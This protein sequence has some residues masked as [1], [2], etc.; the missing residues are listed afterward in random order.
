MFILLVVLL[1]GCNKQCLN[2]CD[3]CKHYSGVINPCDQCK[4][5]YIHVSLTLVIS[6]SIV[7][8]RV[9]LWLSQT[10]VC[11]NSASE[12]WSELT[13]QSITCDICWADVVRCA[14]H[15]LCVHCFICL[16]QCCFC[17]QYSSSVSHW[18][19]DRDWSVDSGMDLWLVNGPWLVSGMD[20]S[21]VSG[22]W[23]VSGMDWSFVNG[24]WQMTSP[25]HWHLAP[26]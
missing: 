13:F 24:P 18:S 22:P 3:Q 8:C 14:M 10:V 25:C 5:I 23:L 11:Q 15:V 19:V 6:V 20:W 4:Y 9:L 1:Q 2:P 16:P 26:L 17:G 21:F 12:L 7:H